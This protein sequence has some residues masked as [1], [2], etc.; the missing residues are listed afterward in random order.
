[1][2]EVVSLQYVDTPH[3][4][5]WPNE[6]E[7][8]TIGLMSPVGQGLP[9]LDVG[10]TTDVPQI[11]DDLLQRNAQVGRVGPEPEVTGFQAWLLR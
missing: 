4:F 10:I 6:F 11:A 8:F 2:G 3:S 7:C 5:Q 9:P 1:M